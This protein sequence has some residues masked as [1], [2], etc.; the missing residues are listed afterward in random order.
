M[1]IG[2]ERTGLEK[3]FFHLCEP[4]VLEAGYRLYD[5]EYVSTNKLVR[6]YIQDPRTGSALIED[7][8]KVDHALTEPFEKESW[9]P[10]DV[11]LEVSS[12]GVYRH[13]VNLEHFRSGLN[14][15]VAVVITGQ[16]SEEQSKSAPKGVKGEKKFRGKLVEVTPQDFTI[17]VSGFGLK[18]TYGQCKKVNLD[19]DLKS[20][21]E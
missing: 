7:C 5:L 1:D 3:K 9:I 4:V 21:R 12:P 2:R 20:A 18:L 13:L 19:P 15:M 16:L 8:I 11:V 17:D 14:E 6:L 10:E